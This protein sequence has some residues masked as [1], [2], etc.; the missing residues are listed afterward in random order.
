MQVIFTAHF[1][2]EAQRANHMLENLSNAS[3]KDSFGLSIGVLNLWN[4]ALELPR[5]FL[6]DFEDCDE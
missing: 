5:A 2:A 6:Y 1:I 3:K 4:L